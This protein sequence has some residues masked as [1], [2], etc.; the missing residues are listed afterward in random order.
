[1]DLRFYLTVCFWAYFICFMQFDHDPKLGEIPCFWPFVSVRQSADADC[2][3]SIAYSP[4][5][6]KNIKKLGSPSM[7]E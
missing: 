1:M 7:A 3:I 4:E 6:I 2:L 5:K